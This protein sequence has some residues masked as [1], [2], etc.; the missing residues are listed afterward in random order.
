[1]HANFTDVYGADVLV[2]MRFLRY[3]L[4]YYEKSVGDHL[5]RY[6]LVETDGIQSHREWEDDWDFEALCDLLL[7][8]FLKDL[9]V[10]RP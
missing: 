10:V 1:M 3:T 8:G 7:E 9:V 6:R 5:L 2:V 4:L